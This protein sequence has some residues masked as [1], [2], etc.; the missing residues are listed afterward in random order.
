M[1]PEEERSH[2]DRLAR[3][4]TTVDAVVIGMGLMIG[5]GIFVGLGPAAEAAG[6]ALIVGLAIAVAV[7]FCNATSS[8]QLAAVSESGGTYVSGESV[9]ARSGASMMPHRVGIRDPFRSPSPSCPEL[10]CEPSRRRR[11]HCR[12]PLAI[13]RSSVCVHGDV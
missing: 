6:T 7:A 12:N 11:E 3:R 4:I 5:A 9:W 1:T 2:P 10:S 8:A 13:R